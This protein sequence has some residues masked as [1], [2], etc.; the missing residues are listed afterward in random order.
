[1]MNANQAMT[2]N[3]QEKM[4]DMESKVEHQEV[5]KDLRKMP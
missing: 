3:N 2:K 5:P 4:E 1:M